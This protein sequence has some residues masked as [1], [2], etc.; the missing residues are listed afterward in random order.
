MALAVSPKDRK[1]RTAS[2]TPSGR[3]SIGFSTL[4]WNFLVFRRRPDPVPGVVD[5]CGTGCMG[6]PS[7]L[8]PGRSSHPQRRPDSRAESPTERARRR[9]RTGCSPRGPLGIWSRR[10]RRR[11]PDLR[12]RLYRA[13]LDAAGLRAP[14]DAGPNVVLQHASMKLRSIGLFSLRVASGRSSGY[15]GPS[16]GLAP[17]RHMS[18]SRSRFTAF[19]RGV[20]LSTI[21]SMASW[22]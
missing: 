20:L 16:S 9:R 17:M 3:W 13:L 4:S 19:Y 8:P 10:C 2:R 5:A 18:S 21:R 7:P 14:S 22:Y 6:C 11:G 15:S 12:Q 1:M